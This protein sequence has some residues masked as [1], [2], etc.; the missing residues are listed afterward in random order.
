MISAC[1]QKIESDVVNETR[2]LCRIYTP[3]PLAFGIVKALGDAPGAMWLEPSHGQGAF[4]RALME[5]N[6]PAARIRAIDLDSHS[7][8][9]D[10]LACTLRGIDFLQWSL[11]SK[12]RF[13]RIVGNPPYLA[14]SQ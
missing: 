8:I 7:C 1:S 6:V 9:H 4:L 3:F 10:R 5:L 2:F 13:E 12:E 11:S 14:I